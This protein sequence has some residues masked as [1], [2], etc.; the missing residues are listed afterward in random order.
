M[1]NII[2]KSQSATIFLRL[3]N[4]ES[5]HAAYK[6]RI[7]KAVNKNSKILGGLIQNTKCTPN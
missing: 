1:Q 6:R 7:K 2:Q 5:I 3:K 4:H